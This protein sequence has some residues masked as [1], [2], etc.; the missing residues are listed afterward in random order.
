[1]EA[2]ARARAAQ[3]DEKFW[4]QSAVQASGLNWFCSA[5]KRVVVP[6]YLGSGDG[7]CQKFGIFTIFLQKKIKSALNRKKFM[8]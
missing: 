4:L 5:R 8:R 1:M 7:G 3:D 6:D 2:G